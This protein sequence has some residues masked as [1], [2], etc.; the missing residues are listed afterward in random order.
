MQGLKGSQM[1]PVCLEIWVSR[2]IL[3]S[4]NRSCMKASLRKL[5]GTTGAASLL[6]VR[7]EGQAS[8]NWFPRQSYASRGYLLAFN[9]WCRRQ[10]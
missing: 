6:L 7:R 5:R 9:Y 10:G 1:L 2:G 8:N 3:A 4:D